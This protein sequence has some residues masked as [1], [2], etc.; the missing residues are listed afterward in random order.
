MFKRVLGF[1]FLTMHKKK[2]IYIFIIIFF[3]FAF[4]LEA[5]IPPA[6]LGPFCDYCLPAFPLLSTSHAILCCVASVNQPHFPQS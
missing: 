3:T 1:I 2:Y 6:I 4:L 5:L